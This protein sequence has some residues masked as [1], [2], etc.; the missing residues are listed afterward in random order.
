MYARFKNLLRV[1]QRSKDAPDRY[2]ISANVEDPDLAVVWVSKYSEMASGEAKAALLSGVRSDVAILADNLEQ[3]IKISRVSTS[4]QRAEQI[5]KLKE[6]LG[7]ARSV[8]LENPTIISD[9]P[10]VGVSGS[11]SGALTYM[12]GSKA[13]EAEI[14]NLEARPSDDPFIPD[15]GE[16][17]ERLQILRGWKVD[18]SLISMYQQDGMVVRPDKPIKPQKGLIMLLAVLFGGGLGLVVAVAR[19]LYLARL[20]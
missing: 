13:L 7:I 12:R 14:A 3:Q 17:K 4:S 8:G 10:S 6:A 9:A 1:E 18:P 5:A 15:L 20:K 19:G 11:M 2:I 16:K